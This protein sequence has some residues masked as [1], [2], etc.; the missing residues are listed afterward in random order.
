[1][2]ALHFILQWCCV[3]SVLDMLQQK[4]TAMHLW[5]DEALAS[6]NYNLSLSS[7]LY[8]MNGYSYW[9]GTKIF[10]TTTSRYI[11][12]YLFIVRQNNIQDARE[13]GTE[14]ILLFAILL[15]F[16]LQI[17]KMQME[18]VLLINSNDHSGP[19]GLKILY[20]Q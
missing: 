18:S 9:K 5:V 14:T 1:M 20:E 13:I 10:W 17:S 6:T 4:V 19:M 7:Y 11:P 2:C 16:E 3:K 8:V 12:K 15:H